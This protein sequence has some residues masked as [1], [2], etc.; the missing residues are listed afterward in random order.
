[1][2]SLSILFIS[3]SNMNIETDCDPLTKNGSLILHPC[4]LIANSF[5]NGNAFKYKPFP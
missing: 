1:M 5:F 4:G 3:Q 2:R